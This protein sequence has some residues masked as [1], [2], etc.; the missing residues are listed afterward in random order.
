MTARLS[1]RY[2]YGNPVYAMNERQ[3]QEN[4]ETVVNDL[5]LRVGELQNMPGFHGFQ[6][7]QFTYERVTNLIL[8]GEVTFVYQRITTNTNTGRRVSPERFGRGS[9]NREYS[10]LFF[11]LTKL[12]FS[13]GAMN[14]TREWR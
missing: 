8:N 5:T 13:Q 2:S 3:E 10:L 6:H 9:R 4:F 12:P 11:N 7:W 1:G 14:L